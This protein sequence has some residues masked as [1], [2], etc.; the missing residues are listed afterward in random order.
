MY[1]KRKRLSGYLLLSAFSIVGG[2]GSYPVLGNPH[3]H[4]ATDLLETMN[5]QLIT[6]TSKTTVATLMLL[7][8][9]PSRLTNTKIERSGSAPTAAAVSWT[10]S[11]EKTV[12][13]YIVDYGPASDPH[14][15]RLA[16]TQPTVTIPQL[17]AGSVVLVKAVNARGLE[18]WDWAS[19][20]ER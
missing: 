16:V 1:Q 18:G 10:P 17:A 4:T 5:H 7:A 6:E 9:S 3:Y 2:I 19:G 14:G 15:H 13:S 12:T 8:S 20:S 11:P